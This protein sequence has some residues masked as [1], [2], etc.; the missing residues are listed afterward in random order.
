M[1]QVEFNYKG[2]MTIIQTN[3]YEKMK[4]IFQKYI[5]KTKIDINSIYFIYSGNNI[6][7]ELSFE[8]IINNEDKM[9]NKMNILVN[10]KN[11]V[12]SKEIICPKCN[13]SIKMYIE[14]YNIFLYECKNGHE[15]DNILFDEFEET[16][17]IDISKIKCD[18]CKKNNKINNNFYMCNKCKKNICQKCKNNHDKTH[19]IIDYDNK[20]YICDK[21]NERYSLYCKL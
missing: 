12:K 20:N 14:D 15:I 16:Q 2:N 19:N 13:E 21:H 17:K 9:K 18:E 7:K 5:E 11:I 1:A 3:K 10:E 6:N 4:Y 8:E